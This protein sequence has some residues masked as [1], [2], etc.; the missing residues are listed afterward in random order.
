MKNNFFVSYVLMK[1]GQNYEAI[2]DAIKS[3]GEWARV[4]QSFFY[5][6]T[7]FSLKEAFDRVNKSIDKND[8]LMIID[9]K[10]AYWIHLPEKVSTYIKENWNR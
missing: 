3:L 6:S 2:E 10:N 4:T 9:A 5:V 1:Q 7:S 8:K